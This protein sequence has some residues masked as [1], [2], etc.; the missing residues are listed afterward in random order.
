MTTARSLSWRSSLRHLVNEASSVQ[1]LLSGHIYPDWIRGA[2]LKPGEIPVFYYHNL[3][4]KRFEQELRYLKRNGYATVTADEYYECVTQERKHQ[5]R[6]VM[7]TFDDGLAGLFDT[8]FP[9][10]KQLN[11]KA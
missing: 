8:I 3:S 11:M 2:P 5:Q 9:L 10:L 1:K 6:L 4:A 7:L